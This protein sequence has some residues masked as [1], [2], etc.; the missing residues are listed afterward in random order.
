MAQVDQALQRAA[1]DI[2]YKGEL[3]GVLEAEV[4]ALREGRTADADVLRRAREAAVAPPPA[5]PV[6]VP[7]V[8]M[9]DDR[10][11]QAVVPPPDPVMSGA[12]PAPV[13]ATSDEEPAESR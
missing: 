11:P 6:V 7:D 1:Y 8:T 4:T 10:T 9:T 3:I 2:G 13:R 5:E 12:E